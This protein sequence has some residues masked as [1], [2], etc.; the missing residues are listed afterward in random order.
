MTKTP[1]HGGE[2][3]HCTDLVEMVE[4]EGG[5]TQFEPFLRCVQCRAQWTRDGEVLQGP[6]SRGAWHDAGA[7]TKR[8]SDA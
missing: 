7:V 4:P 3:P 5:V 2:C 1:E 8:R 6:A